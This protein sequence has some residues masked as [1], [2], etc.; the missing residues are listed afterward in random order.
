MLIGNVLEKTEAVSAWQL[1]AAK[2][3]DWVRSSWLGHRH[4]GIAKF[5]DS[6]SED[7][8]A[9]LGLRAEGFGSVVGL[10]YIFKWWG[11]DDSEGLAGMVEV[12]WKLMEGDGI[13]CYRTWIKLAERDFILGLYKEEGAKRAKNRNVPVY[14]VT[15]IHDGH[16]GSVPIGHAIRGFNELC[17]AE[18]RV[19]EAD[20]A[21]AEQN[22]KMP[23]AL[24]Y[25]GPA[26]PFY[27][28][29]K[30]IH[31]RR[32]SANVR[33][34]ICEGGHTGNFSAGMD[35]LYRQV[36][37][38]PVDWTIPAKIEGEALFREITK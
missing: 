35:F 33:L 16:T 4:E 2:L 5:E 38:R 31:F 22:E 36:K 11:A 17:R 24:V 32:T 9:L 19:G 10:D 3:A 26:D 27:S 15:G 20:I 29:E 1:C 23:E 18:D 13:V 6:M 8:N 25:K 34:T 28:A 12:I 30:F 7:P 37:N 21:F 14:I